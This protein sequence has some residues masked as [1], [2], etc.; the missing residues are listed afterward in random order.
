MKGG[1]IIAVDFDGTLCDEAWP[2]IGEVRKGV[3]EYVKHQ[4]AEGAS[5][6]LWTCR[7]GER[8][9][10]AV[11]WCNDHGLELDAV[12]ENLPDVIAVFGGDCRK[13]YADE[14]VEDKAVIPE[15]A[16]RRMGM[17][18]RRRRTYYGL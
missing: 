3:L 1:R 6:V 15:E 10:E 2:G 12:N 11:R 5:I 9:E 13:I 17:S 14:Y 16:E 8:L 4:K 18:G 7:R